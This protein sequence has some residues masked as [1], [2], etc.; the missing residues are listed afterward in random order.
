[1]K[2]ET[3]VDVGDLVYRAS[4]D[5]SNKQVQCPD[6]LGTR[7]WEAHLP[8]GEIIPITCPAC[9]YGFESRG[10]VLV[11]E[12]VGS[13]AR[14]TVGSCE[15]EMDRREGH[16]G[17]LAERYMCEETGVGSGT[18]HYGHDLCESHAEAEDQLP[19][20]VKARQVQLEESH[21]T[22]RRRKIKNGPGRMAACYRAQIRSARKSIAAAERGL[23]R[24]AATTEETS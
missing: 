8:N 17:E 6:C 3:R 13:V 23:E 22:S 20:M 18:V 2:I 12:V 4:A 5:W 7:S 11:G 24:E 15:V 16:E 9:E 21:A 14:L 19:A 10:T 1:M